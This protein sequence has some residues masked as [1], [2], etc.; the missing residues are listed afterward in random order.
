MSTTADLM[1]LGMAAALAGRLGFTPATLVTTGTSAGTAAAIQTKLTILTTA[2][3][4]TGA[5]LPSAASLGAS[6]IVTNPTATAGVVY[7]P[8]GN[9]FNTSASTSIAI[10]QYNTIIFMR[11]SSTTW[12][13]IVSA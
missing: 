1:G 13:T 7:P 11:T 12:C 3:S 9:T 4:Q 6:Y 10:A 2:G 5:I 8:T